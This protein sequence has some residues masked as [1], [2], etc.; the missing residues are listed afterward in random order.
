MKMHD[1]LEQQF[2]QQQFSNGY[3]LVNGV[4]MH[5]ENPDSFQIPHPVLK[6]HV[7]VGHFIELRIDSPRFSVHDDAVEKCYC[8]TCNGEAT[9]P[10]HRCPYARDQTAWSFLRWDAE[11]P[12][13]LQDEKP[14]LHDRLPATHGVRAN[15]CVSQA[16]ALPSSAE[17]PH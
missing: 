10:V 14:N 7:V 6:K 13:S 1:T 12:G 8:P 5:A 9:K 17:S 16:K 4:E 11:P 3:E 15:P 2:A